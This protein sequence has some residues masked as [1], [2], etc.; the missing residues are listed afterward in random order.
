VERLSITF[1][2]VTPLFLGGADPKQS[3]ELRA[4]SIKGALRFWYRAINPEYWKDESKIFGSTDTGQGA[5]L[6]RLSNP[7]TA[8]EQWNK[9]YYKALNKDEHLGP[10]FIKNGITYLGYSLDMKGNTKRF[11][12]PATTIN[13]QLVLR[14]NPESHL[15]NALLASIWL[16]GHIGGLGSR[17]RR[18]FGTVALKEW[19]WNGETVDILRVAHGANT[20]A[21]WLSTFSEG[22]NMLRKWFAKNKYVDHSVFGINTKFYLFHGGQMARTIDGK[23]FKPWEMALFEAGLK[24]QTFR[25]RWNP[26]DPN[27]DY[28]R[29]KA[30]LASVDYKVPAASFASAIKLS[31]APERA[32]FGLPL[33]FRY[34][35]LKYQKT[36]LDGSPRFKHDGKPDYKVPESTFQGEK[37][38]RN[39]SPVHIRI[40]QIGDR[41][42]PLFVWID[43][44][45]LSDE[46][47]VKDAFGSY[48]KNSTSILDSFWKEVLKTRGTEVSW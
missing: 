22:L 29:V 37:H 16:L 28:H 1:E 4:P 11:I 7:V 23:T 12:S 45:L 20:P 40:I 25:Q 43:A 6:M 42:H 13:I 18:G 14:Q 27:S 9:N 5:F 15:K 47:N 33:T 26:T 21:A 46:E 31:L 38:D 34:G 3:A 32:A 35:S 2:T 10:A 36:N 41:A 17:S 8:S 19:S 44:P 24:M 30:H 39:A 48:P